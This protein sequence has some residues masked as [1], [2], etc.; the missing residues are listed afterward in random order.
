MLVGL[1]DLPRVRDLCAILSRDVPAAPRELTVETKPTEDLARFAAEFGYADLP[2]SAREH[3]RLL[4]LDSIACALASDYG[5][6]TGMYARFAR[7]AGG[8]A[9]PP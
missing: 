1:A 3:A 7:A 9:T 6:E 2:A 8:P 5:Q 4:L